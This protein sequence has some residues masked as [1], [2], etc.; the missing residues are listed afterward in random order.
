MLKTRYKKAGWF[1]NDVRK[2]YP[3][4]VSQPSLPSLAISNYGN[5]FNLSLPSYF[6]A[7]YL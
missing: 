3:I 5:C 4:L 2:I 7:L 6:L 1:E